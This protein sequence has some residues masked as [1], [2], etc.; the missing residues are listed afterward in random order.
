MAAPNGRLSDSDCT[1]CLV[2]GL[3]EAVGYKD[4]T[5]CYTLAEVRM[6]DPPRMRPPPKSG[7]PPPH[8]PGWTPTLAQ[9]DSR[10]RPKRGPEIPTWLTARIAN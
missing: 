10:I 1:D 2:A 9:A 7:T 3:F 5:A 4:K 6:G 8:P